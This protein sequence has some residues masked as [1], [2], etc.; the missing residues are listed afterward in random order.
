MQS[1]IR[2]TESTRRIQISIKANVSL[3]ITEKV[4]I[5]II[6]TIDY[7]F[8][9]SSTVGSLGLSTKTVLCTNPREGSHFVGLAVEDIVVRANHKCGCNWV[10]ERD[11]STLARN[12]FT[13]STVEIFLLST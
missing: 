1:N 10:P 4:S 9:L 13:D 5:Q 7:R 8:N 3:A 11:K 2:K 12:T 6:L